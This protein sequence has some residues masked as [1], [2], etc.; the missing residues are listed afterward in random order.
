MKSRLTSQ[1]GSVRQRAVFLALVAAALAVTA[2]GAVGYASPTVS[3]AQQQYAPQNTAAPTIS[4]TPRVGQTL[5]ASNGTFTGDQPITYT[6]QWQRCDQNGSNC[7]NIVGATGQ[8]YVL[9]SADQARTLRVVVTAT[10]A[11]GSTAATSVPTGVVQ[12]AAPAGPAGQIRL[13]GGGVSIPATSVALPAR[14][15][16][17]RVQFFPNPVR[18][19]RGAITVRVRVRDTRGF[20]VRGALVFFRSTPLLTTTPPEQA[21]QTNGTVTFRIFPRRAFPLRNGYYVQF[22]V[23]ARKAGDNVLAGVSTRRLVQLR[24]ATPR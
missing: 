12:A 20:F 14:L 3:A 9:T 17:D 2:F 19:R 8:T 18:S 5:T 6:Y 10:N 23:R 1:A 15:I 22:F 21:T 11:R 24:T 7:S 4:G 16:V 13:P